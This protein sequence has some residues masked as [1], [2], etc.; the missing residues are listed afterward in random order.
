MI[1]MEIMKYYSKRRDAAQRY[2]PPEINVHF[3]TEALPFAVERCFRF[4]NLLTNDWLW[5]GLMKGIYKDE[6]GE[7]K[8]ER[9]RKNQEKIAW[10]KSLRILWNLLQNKLC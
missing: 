7:A 4:E 5:L 1:D 2:V 3:I 6:F 9:S 10:I 8:R